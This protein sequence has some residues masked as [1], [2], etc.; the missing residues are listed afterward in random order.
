MD[1][2]GKAAFVTG[3]SHGIGRAIALGLA[4]NNAAL[5]LCTLIKQG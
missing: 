4:K 5:F 2:S 3:V 1:F